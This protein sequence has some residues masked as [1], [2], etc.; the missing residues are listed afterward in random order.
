[1]TVIIQ[2][3]LLLINMS[4]FKSIYAY[5]DATSIK[6]Y[7]FEQMVWYYTSYYVILSFVWNGITHEISRKVL[8]G[9]LAT[10]LLKPISVKA[11]RRRYQEFLLKRIL[12]AWK[13]L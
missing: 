10:D 6:G 11:C 2:S 7:D 12:P 9:Q 4:L 5:N 13:I 8:S 3:I 1:M